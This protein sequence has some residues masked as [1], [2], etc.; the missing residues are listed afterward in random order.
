VTFLN[1]VLFTLA[2]MLLAALPSFSQVDSVIAQLSNSG[3]ESFGGS[4]SGDG[5]FV[6]FESTGDIATVNPRNADHNKEIFLLDYAQ[7]RIFQITNTKSV[8]YDDK[9]TSEVQTNIRVEITNSRPQISND[10]RWIVFG[11]NATSARPA[12]PDST[13]P[14]SFDG[15]AFTTPTPTPNP[16]ASPTPSPSP[17]AS[18]TPTP[19]PGANALTQ[20]GNM[21]M[22]IYHVPATPA[23]AN[24]SLG[25]EQPFTDLTGGSFTRLTNTDPSQLPRGG[26]LNNGPVVADDNHDASIS[27]DGNAVAFVSNRDLVPCVGNAGPTTANPSGDDNDEIYTFHQG[28]AV[29]C[30]GTPVTPGEVGVN[31]V[32]KTPRG[33]V[34]N[35]I[36]NKNPTISGNGLRV[37]FSSTGDNPVVGMSGGTN[38]KASRN[39]EIFYADLNANGAPI[40]GK[41]VTNTVGT[42]AAP[43]VNILD[44]GRRLS[45]DGRF[46][47][48]DSTADLVG[49]GA[50]ATGYA[51]FVYDITANT[52]RQ[53]GPRSDADTAA[54]GGDVNHYPGFTDYVGGVPQ[55]LVFETREN[56][57]SDGTVAATIT[58]GL[59][60]DASRPAQLYSYQLSQPAA[61]A[62]L[63]RLANFPPA[64]AIIG[65]AQP[66][67]SNSLTRMAFTIAETELGTGNFDL[68]SEVYYLIKPNVTGEVTPVNSYSTGASHLPIANATPAASPT[69]TPTP[70]P[71]PVTPAN[72]VGMSPGMLA[73]L[74]YTATDTPIATRTGVGDLTRSPVLPAELSGVTL[75]I[76]GAACLLKN[77][78]GR[79][80]DFIVP[81]GLT[82]ASDGSKSYPFVLINNGVV[83]RG[84]MVIVPTRPDIFR[85]DNVAA[86]GGRTKAFNITNRV[87]TQEPFVIRTVKIKGGLFTPSL[88]RV[89]ATGLQGI[90]PTTVSIRLKD[91]TVTAA[92]ITPIEPGVWGIDFFL[93]QAMLGL[94]D[95]QVVV[96]VTFN[97]VTFTSRLDDTTSFTRIL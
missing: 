44:Y 58:D 69:A 82:S 87:H 72:V 29:P 47:A 62:K 4:M 52:F 79:H 19:T 66:L 51:L 50:N 18:P 77:V 92:A 28:G 6:V 27:D 54:T 40:L 56:I 60:Q 97:N 23:V 12:A 83:M 64:G 25:D 49:G 2:A 85:L 70:S 68:Q 33:E 45:R 91:Q 11:S 15:N 74:D 93:T 9:I 71:T 80:V 36:Y 90:D 96:T 20:D 67:P 53:V 73:T 81:A 8:Y 59:N 38:P 24:L 34:S 22:W 10:G 35:P 16:T 88:I 26:S 75:T 17:T 5:R 13:N 95:S 76:N 78:S 65:E 3:F 89:Y 42:V 32:T 31:Q 41:Q 48:F 55:T 61:T 1:K 21:E 84:T 14:G 39:E 94:G 7:R 43:V 57:K 37:A 30:P 63:T 86:P 46:I